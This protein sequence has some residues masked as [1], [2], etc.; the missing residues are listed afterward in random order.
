[1]A[2]GPGKI[3]EYNKTLTPAQRK[4]NARKAGKASAKKRSENPTRTSDIRAIAKIINE[5]P[6]SDDVAEAIKMVNVQDKTMSNAAAI[7]LAVFQAAID[8]DMKA[9]EKWEHYVGQSDEAGGAG[10]QIIDDV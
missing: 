7:A 6:L 10:V 4:K 9:V 1:M 2:G 5:A 8:G 3:N